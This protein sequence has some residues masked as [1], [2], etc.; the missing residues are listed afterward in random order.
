MGRR[1]L[2]RASCGWFG[3]L[4][5]ATLLLGGCRSGLSPTV[6]VATPSPTV[7]ARPA[8]TA[9]L[10]APAT[11][12]PSPAMPAD[13][14]FHYS[15][16]WCGDVIE[17]DTFSGT[18]TAAIRGGTE[19]DTVSFAPTPAE[20]FAFY[21]EIE[22]LDF[23][24][25]PSSLPYIVATATWGDHFLEVRADGRTKSLQWSDFSW[26][27]TPT[28]LELRVRRFTSAFYKRITERSELRELRG[29][30]VSCT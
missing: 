24:S 1:G 23:F 14:A 3:G 28:V 7:P 20:L 4:L 6:A 9:T 22:V 12:T 5:V 18:Y 26:A 11:P 25:L 17:V 16:D 29:R 10:G 30:G 27:L 2:I 19:R 8:P 13:F 21:D 15:V